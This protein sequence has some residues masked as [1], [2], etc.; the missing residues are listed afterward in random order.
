MAKMCARAGDCVQ[1]LTGRPAPFT[2]RSLTKMTSTLTLSDRRA[3]EVFGWSP[4]PVLERID[5]LV[6]S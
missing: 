5:E 4:T 6:R 3:R 2:S 1:S